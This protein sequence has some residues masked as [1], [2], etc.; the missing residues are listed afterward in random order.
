MF[1]NQAPV[2]AAIHYL[3]ELVLREYYENW[4][5]LLI[6]VASLRLNKT[7]FK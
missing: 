4:L 6:T 7:R 5:Q 1:R 3:F 2:N